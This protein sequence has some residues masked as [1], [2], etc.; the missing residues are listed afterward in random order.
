MINAQNLTFK[1]TDKII[2]NNISFNIPEGRISCFIGSS[3][4]GKTSLL[5]CIANLNKN[6]SGIL[7]YNNIQTKTMSK[8]QIAKL[9][10]YVSQQFNLF[11]HMSI[12]KNCMQ[13]LQFVCGI[14]KQIA[15]T[16]ALEKLKLLGIEEFQNE[17]PNNL[18][19]GQQQRAAI[20][21]ALCL[22]PKVLLLDE[23]SSSL[24]P[25][26]TKNLQNI[27]KELCDKGITIVF[28]SHDMSLVSNLLDNVYLMSDGEI[29]EECDT[30][31]SSISA[32]KNI[33]AFIGHNS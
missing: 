15:Q 33:H 19:G 29:I 5:K 23:P 28:T 21:R 8:Q 20:A 31:K 18:S 17:Y 1:Y 25:F 14:S 27:L 13:P 4:A 10:G 30:Q 24:D 11:P 2:L 32:T 26:N 7:K 9:I 6:Y 16:K 22:E 3:G 12:L